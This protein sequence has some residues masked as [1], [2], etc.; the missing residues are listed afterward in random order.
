MGYLTSNNPPAGEFCQRGGMVIPGYYKDEK[1][2]K[3][4]IDEDGWFHSGDIVTV[5][6]KGRFKI[7]DRKKDL[8][9]L[10]QGEYVS[11]EKIANVYSL[12]PL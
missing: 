6:E 9:K 1:K 7:V 3:E 4:V 5:D 12:C 10:S 2:T 8:L 11:C